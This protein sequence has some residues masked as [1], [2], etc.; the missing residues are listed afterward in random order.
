MTWKRQHPMVE[1]LEGEY[2]DGVRL[3]AKEMKPYEARLHRSATLPKYDIV[4]KPD[5]EGSRVK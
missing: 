4:I 2:P 1:C 5:A 3:P